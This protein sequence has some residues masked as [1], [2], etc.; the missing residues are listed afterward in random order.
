MTLDEAPR[1]YDMFKKKQDG[2]IKVV[3]KPGRNGRSE[4]IH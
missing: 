2:C 1:A 4:T 3:L